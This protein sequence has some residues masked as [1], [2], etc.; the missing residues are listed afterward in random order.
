MVLTAKTTLAIII[1]FI[2]LQFINLFNIENLKIKLN[3]EVAK[4]RLYKIQLDT[5]KKYPKWL[6][7]AYDNCVPEQS[8]DV[9]LKQCTIFNLETDIRW[10]DLQLK[11]N[12]M[13]NSK[14][15]QINEN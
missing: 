14:N 9:L 10:D 4:E 5:Y 2:M 7:N 13:Y 15:T 1:V 8:P 11:Y 3:K 12:K 6:Y